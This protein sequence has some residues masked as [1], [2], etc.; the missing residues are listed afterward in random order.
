MT[1]LP[2]LLTRLSQTEHGF[3]HVQVAGDDLLSES[4]VLST[5]RELLDDPRYSSRMLAVHILGR[6]SAT[7]PEA[8]GILRTTV[9]ADS[10]WRVQE[11]LAK[12]VDQYGK[13]TGYEQ[14][15][16]LFR[17]WLSSDQPNLKRAVTE[18]LR[19][20]T[21]RPYFKQHPEVA[22]SMISEHRADPSEY[23]RRSVGNALRDIRRK[24]PK[25]VD[26]EI[27]GW[28]RDDPLIRLTLKLATQ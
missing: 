12:A 27:A 2:S 10:D 22:V 5:A 16:P 3:K 18:G 26:A 6:I 11:M 7:T 17:D 23:L 15:L 1:D 20:W 24:F 28:D 19:I 8:L 14:A 13:D 25:L 4:D 9:A 21:S